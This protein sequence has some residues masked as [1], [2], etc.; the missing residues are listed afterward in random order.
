MELLK[1][2]DESNKTTLVLALKDCDWREFRDKLPEEYLDCYITSEDLQ[3]RIKVFASTKEKELAEILPTEGNI[4]SGDFGEMLSYFLFK[5]RH[6][7]EKVNGPKKW[8]WKQ[9]KNVAAPYTD[10][11]LFAIKDI[12]NPSGD[13]LILA[14][15]SKMKSVK[16]DSYDPIQNAI[17]GAEKDYVS[18]I[19]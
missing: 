17:N 11:I 6:K 18:R 12:K 16:N 1:H 19:A 8:R 7:R 5:E 9:E 10:V 14:V 2:F 4:R 3:H 13:D 15:E